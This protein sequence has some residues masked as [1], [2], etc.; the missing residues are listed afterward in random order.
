MKHQN[1]ITKLYIFIL[2]HLNLKH[3][4]FHIN[5]DVH[6]FSFQYFHLRTFNFGDCEM[7]SFF[8]IVSMT[9]F[10]VQARPVGG[11]FAVT[12]CGDSRVM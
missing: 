10:T 11:R 4:Q 8:R 2:S 3:S 1:L 9:R 12:G 6:R 7:L 5:D